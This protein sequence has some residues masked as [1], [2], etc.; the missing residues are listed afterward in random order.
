MM[1]GMARRDVVAAQLLV[2]GQP[3]L[4]RHE[5][6]QDDQFGQKLPGLLQSFGAVGRAVH[7]PAGVLHDGAHA[8]HQVRV[9]VDH[10]Q[11]HGLHYSG[12][13]RSVKSS[14]G[15]CPGPRQR[16][17]HQAGQ[18]QGDSRPLD[19]L[20]P[21]PEHEHAAQHRHQDAA[22]GEV[23]DEAHRALVAV[24]ELDHDHGGDREQDPQRREGVGHRMGPMPLFQGTRP[25]R[26]SRARSAEPE[27]FWKRGTKPPSTPANPAMTGPTT[28]AAA[29]AGRARPA[30][31][32][33]TARPG[34]GNSRR[35]EGSSER[36]LPLKQARSAPP[37]TA[38]SSDAGQ[39][40]G[41]NLLLHDQEGEQGQGGQPGAGHGPH[42]GHAADARPP[43]SRSA[44]P[45]SCPAG[46]RPTAAAAP[47]VAPHERQAELLA[48]L[49]DVQH[50]VAD[51]GQ[52]DGEPG[53]RGH[54]VIKRA[55]R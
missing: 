4:A 25:R 27:T 37:S 8:G 46:S 45:R 41:A 32:R 17:Q 23:G 2:G 34:R 43:T 54:L 28:P 30:G 22:G 47:P 18:D 15:P 36:E 44:P 11:A 52:Q 48:G 53:H 42:Q 14:P 31:P 38:M 40:A 26:R 49:G 50:G 39:L 13:R 33:R 9:V 24:G 3:V 6:V 51:E 20:Q 16:E 29:G 35:R 7:L 1:I 55:K 19:G 12:A 10:Q 5:D 21:L